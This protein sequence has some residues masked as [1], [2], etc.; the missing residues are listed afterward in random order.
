MRTYAMIVV[1]A[2][3][4]AVMPA[5][6]ASDPAH[7]YSREFRSCMSAAIAAGNTDHDNTACNYAEI[8]RQDDRLNQ[9][10][11]MIML[12]LNPAKKSVLRESERKW[13]VSK[14]EGCRRD[15]GDDVGGTLDEVIISDCVLRQTIERIIYLENY[16][17]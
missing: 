2:A 5:Y 3:A 4:G 17:P 13:I 14:K 8:Q 10:Y 7:R 12:R 6:A 15:R 9:A 1:I 11:K 16:H